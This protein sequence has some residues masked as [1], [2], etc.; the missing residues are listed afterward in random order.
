MDSWKLDGETIAF[1]SARRRLAAGSVQE[2]SLQDKRKAVLDQRF[3]SAATALHYDGEKLLV[4]T[5]SGALFRWDYNDPEAKPELVVELS[6]GVI[7]KSISST[8]SSWILLAEGKSQGELVELSKTG[9]VQRKVSFEGRGL[10]NLTLTA[11]RR[12]LATGPNYTLQFFD[13]TSGKK[14]GLSL[15]HI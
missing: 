10:R 9:K 1:D 8:P 14:L 7:V 13:Q 11:S 6:G 4:G 12:V 2:V 5:E 3:E 15:I